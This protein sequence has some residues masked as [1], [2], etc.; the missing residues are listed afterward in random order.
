MLKTL[1]D[2]SETLTVDCSRLQ[3]KVT[4]KRINKDLKVES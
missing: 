4:I 3:F 2:E 1:R